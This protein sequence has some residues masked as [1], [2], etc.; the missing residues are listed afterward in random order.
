MSNYE[1]KVIPAPRKAEKIKGVRNGDD[2]FAHTITNTINTLAEDG[3]EYL[4]AE[5]LPVDEKASMIGKS[6]EKYLSL[7]VFRREMFVEPEE[8]Q[9][10]K[11]EAPKVADPSMLQTLTTDSDE[12]EE[13]P[14]L[15]A[16]T[17]D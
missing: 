10:I 8:I 11:V 5:S 14:P 15:G 6:V 2:R 1:F 7:L 13:V 3:W 9:E 17:R 16:A 12:P 4:R